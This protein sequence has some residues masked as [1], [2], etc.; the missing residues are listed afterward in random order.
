MSIF[1]LER[2]TEFVYLCKTLKLATTK[3]EKKISAFR[4][5]VDGI[6]MKLKK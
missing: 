5:I 4:S 1:N 3:N 6:D 2:I